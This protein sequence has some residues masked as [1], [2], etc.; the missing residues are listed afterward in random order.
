MMRTSDTHASQDAGFSLVELSVVSVL[1]VLILGVAYMLMDVSGRMV[2]Q[3]QATSIAS[4]ESR[5]ALDRMGQEL[6][7]SMEI[8]DTAGV[9]A[10]TAG[11][12]ARQM[13]LYCDLKHDNYVDRITYYMN[14]QSLMRKET[15]ATTQIGVTSA[16]AW[17]TE[18]TP[19]VVVA[20]ISPSY[21]GAIFTYF[22]PDGTAATT[23][24]AASAVNV[25]I[26]DQVVSGKVTV[27]VDVSSYTR[28]RSVLNSIN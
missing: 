4:D 13:I 1:L 16:P 15:S 2:D 23:P 9:F 25:R 18:T 7:Q 3:A 27:N 14:G 24:A 22:T 5:L 6:R 21:A 20:R 10:G 17:R 8:T 12:G 28:I 19:K 26:V 11:M